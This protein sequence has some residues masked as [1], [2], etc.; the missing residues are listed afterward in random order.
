LVVFLICK[1]INISAP[2]PGHP[3]HQASFYSYSVQQHPVPPPPPPSSTAPVG[4][5]A[6]SA[7]LASS[8]SSSSQ[9]NAS[10]DHAS[11]NVQ[12]GPPSVG[13]GSTSAPGPTEF[14]SEKPA[15]PAPEVKKVHVELTVPTVTVKEKLPV[16]KAEKPVD[17]KPLLPPPQLPTRPLVPPVTNLPSGVVLPTTP[18]QPQQLNC[19]VRPHKAAASAVVTQ[20]PPAVVPAVVPAVASKPVTS[21]QSYPSSVSPTTIQAMLANVKPVVSMA[22]MVAGRSTLRNYRRAKNPAPDPIK[23][24][25]SN[26]NGKSFQSVI[27]TRTLPSDI[28]VTPV[29]TKSADGAKRPIE[30]Q[31]PSVSCYPI[32]KE[33]ERAQE[34]SIDDLVAAKKLKDEQ[35]SGVPGSQQ[36][37]RAFQLPKGLTITEISSKPEK[38]A[39]DKS[40]YEVQALPVLHIPEVSSGGGH[41]YD[42][43]KKLDEASVAAPDK[44]V[45][46]VKATNGGHP[47][48]PNGLLRLTASLQQKSD[49]S[50]PGIG[51]VTP[52][53]TPKDF[54]SQQALSKIGLSIGNNGFPAGQVTILRISISGKKFSHKF[55]LV[56]MDKVSSKNCRPVLMYLTM[57][58]E[59]LGFSSTTKLL[60]TKLTNLQLILLN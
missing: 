22:Q 49:Y 4:A 58:D 31:P 36:N 17:Q 47:G 15:K 14:K 11:K 10:A 48:M 29:L 54:K 59:I 52:K 55:F 24:D 32:S 33:V 28:S 39:G 44:K 46:S 42:L 34:M 18:L 56:K 13:K 51:K 5:P 27:G 2:P 16:S 40:G 6:A 8:S 3:A 57:M 38:P 45:S 41:H 35:S 7:T 12:A 20:P 26:G 25:T 9:E 19:S 43:L 53:V 1:K 60:K 21:A 30:H 50:R 37:S 23:A